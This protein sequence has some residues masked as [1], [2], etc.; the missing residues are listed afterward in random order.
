MAGPDPHQRLPYRVELAASLGSL[1]QTWWSP[2][3]REDMVRG[4][5]VELGTTEA[6]LLWELGA[7]GA[8]RSGAL[9][10]LLDL[11]APSIS[12]GVAKLVSRG[13]V[14]QVRDPS[15]GRGVLVDLTA[16]G[17]AVTQR[18]YDVGDRVVSEVLST[19]S[20]QDAR[21]LTV[22]AGRF[23]RDAIAHASRLR[24]RAPDRSVQHDQAG[25]EM[26]GSA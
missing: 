5:G 2:A 11:G 3:F 21:S 14:E 4:A 18:L 13:L 12:K 6:R 24:S 17:R 7:R 16:E 20:D 19:W 25:A 22:L 1:V 9:A 23:S 26:D 15:D 8:Q 10:A